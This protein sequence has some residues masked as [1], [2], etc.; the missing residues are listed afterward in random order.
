[1][2]VV[3]SNRPHQKFETSVGSDRF[4]RLITGMEN[5]DTDDDTDNNGNDDD[6]TD[7]DDDRFNELSPNLATTGVKFQGGSYRN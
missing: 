5:A 1:M 3:L 4:F 7:V 6:D 2:K